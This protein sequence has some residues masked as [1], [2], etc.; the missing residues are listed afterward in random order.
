MVKSV[1]SPTLRPGCHFVPHWRTMMLPATTFS[2]PNFFTPR[3]CGLL[4]RPFLDE[5]T[6]FLCAMRTPLSELDVAD[7]NFSE[8]L[9][10]SLLLG[11]VL[12]ALHLEDDDF[13]VTTLP[14]DLALD[15]RSLERGDT[16]DG[17]VAVGAEDDVAERDLRP[18]VSGQAG[19]SNCLAGLGAVLLATCPDDC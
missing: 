11:V 13:L 14:D 12:P 9:P 6:P 2:P 4:S 19:D 3:Y 17:L 16:D 8:A 18:F 15:G 1:P 5:P 10:V 7:A